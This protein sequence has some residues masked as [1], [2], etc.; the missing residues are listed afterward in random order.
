VSESLHVVCPACA[1]V[2]RVPLDRLE[3]APTCGRCK[4]ALF[5]GVPVELDADGFRRLLE[6]SEQP[7]LVDFWAPW[8]GPCRQMAPQ[9][10]A[11]TRRLEPRVRVAKIDIEAHQS[12]GAALRI[13]SIPTLAL[14]HG[15]REIARTQG[16]LGANDIVRFV[17][18]ALTG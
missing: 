9:L 10:L 12:I 2:N 3:A 16:A 13:Q 15:G 8:C 17:A 14:Y 7:V 1:A 4:A 18:E 11:A 6:R 5:G